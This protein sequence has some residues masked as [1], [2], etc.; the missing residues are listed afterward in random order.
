[1][2][3]QALYQEIVTQLQQG[4]RIVLATVIDTK[5]STPRKTGSSMLVREDGSLFGTI[6]GGCG[7]AGVIQKARLALVD[8]QVREDMA[9]LTEEISLESEAVCGGVMRVFIE[10]WQPKHLDVAQ[11]LAKAVHS[12]VRVHT[13]VHAQSHDSPN[14]LGARCIEQVN[15][16][17]LY[18]TLP[19]QSPQP[20]K[21][22]IKRPLQRLEG[23]EFYTELWSPQ[24]CLVIVGAGHI[25]EPLETFAR[26]SGYTTVVIDD[27]SL[28][29]NRQ[30]FPHAH[31]VICAPILQACQN[32]PLSLEH[33]IVLVTRGHT[34]DMDALRVLTNRPEK[35]A[36]LG[37]IGSNR[38]V[39]AVFSL[40]EKEGM[41]REQFGDVHSPIGLNIGAET[42]HEIAISILAEIIANK[43][44]VQETQTLALR[45]LSG[46]HPSLHPR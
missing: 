6:G 36:Y 24:P 22:R 43:K 17:V 10:P 8:G 33:H 2:S 34:L 11:Q 15:G 3:H 38:R 29:A 26:M 5:G 41:P 9:D 45:L 46:K 39:C 20:T 14:A 30:R 13:L 4:K 21:G 35:C 42:P 25:A 1:M 23:W 32:M 44:G 18:N 7:E 40:L 16:Q 31:Q 28:F 37:M 19:K 12:N 27:R